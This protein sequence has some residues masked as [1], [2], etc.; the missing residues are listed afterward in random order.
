M[1]FARSPEMGRFEERALFKEMERR[2]HEGKKAFRIVKFRVP[3][4]IM[5]DADVYN[6]TAPF[7]GVIV[8]RVEKRD[9]EHSK[10]VF[11]KYDENLVSNG[12]K[13]HVDDSAAVFE[14]LQ[15]PFFSEHAQFILF[16]GVKLISQQ[17]DSSTFRTVIFKANDVHGL[18]PNNVFASGPLGEKDIRVL[19]LEEN[20]VIVSRRP[21]GGEY[22]KGRIYYQ[23]IG[24]VDDLPKTL[25]ALD[26]IR[27]LSTP[28]L[29]EHYAAGGWA[30]VNQMLK[31]ED[32][33]VGVIG[34]LGRFDESGGR[35][36]SAFALKLDPRTGDATEFKIIAD[37]GSVPKMDPKRPDL[38]DVVFPG[39][40]VR[41]PDGTA[42]LFLGVRD[43]YS[44][45]LDLPDPFVGS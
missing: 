31:L 4:R 32:G 15:D 7:H 12:N 23:L 28:Q 36:Y 33:R 21:Q 24:G 29:D 13:L 39:G 45:E 11:F 38:S 8:G 1:A 44:V 35:N 26:G 27:Y 41:H 9:S 22:G 37:I 42:R 5:K 10:S 34:H 19:Q 40:L 17:K 30:G 18:D 2:F 6:P 25:A 14:N 3:S 16:G 43:S 20:S